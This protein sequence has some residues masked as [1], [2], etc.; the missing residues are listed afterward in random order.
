MRHGGGMAGRAARAWLAGIGLAIALG[1]TA[2]ALAQQPN[3][4]QDLAAMIRLWTAT[5]QYLEVQG[6][7]AGLDI[8]AA[9]DVKGEVVGDRLRALVPQ[10]DVEGDT[11]TLTFAPTSVTATPLDQDRYQ[12]TYSQAVSPTLVD[13]D[14]NP[15]ARISIGTGRATAIWHRRESLSRESKLELS[16][17]L[18]DGPPP[19]TKPGAAS[20]PTGQLRI[21]SVELIETNDPTRQA[22]MTLALS[23]LALKDPT[24]TDMA[25]IG[26][27]TIDFASFGSVNAYAEA[28]VQ[29]MATLNWATDEPR[30]LGQATF[31]QFEAFYQ[32]LRGA[33]GRIILEDLMVLGTATTPAVTLAR[34]EVGLEAVRDGADLRTSLT[35]EVTGV[36][37]PAAVDLLPNGLFPERL[38]LRISLADSVLPAMGPAILREMR[39]AVTRLPNE[40]DDIYAVPNQVITEA[41]TGLADEMEQRWR[42]ASPRARLEQLDLVTPLGRIE[43]MAEASL[44]AD[45][46][47]PATGRGEVSITNLEAMT[48]AAAAGGQTLGGGLLAAGLGMATAFGKLEP[49]SQPPR[50]RIEA[51]V[52]AKGDVLVNGAPMGS[53]RTEKK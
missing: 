16:D 33:S 22:Q 48:K 10:V 44:P 52:D 30:P 31:E 3:R 26:R 53:V 24:G 20:A 15:L 28:V 38:Q 2:P 32:M 46:A 5:L 21:A 37:S 51:T 12:I 29:A 36:A 45:A 43:V 1:V 34:L 11:W 23:G 49:D 41:F 50:H 9:D 35:L 6:L 17:I 47:V 19:S 42:V 39:R 18:I 7:S 8:T 4:D 40:V 27:L 13:G 25:R 14:G